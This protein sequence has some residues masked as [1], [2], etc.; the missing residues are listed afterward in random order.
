MELVTLL[1]PAAVELAP[2]RCVFATTAPSLLAEAPTAVESA[3]MRWIVAMAPVP[4]LL[5]MR[6]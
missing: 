5:S 4:G 2:M 3:P 6:W 1:I